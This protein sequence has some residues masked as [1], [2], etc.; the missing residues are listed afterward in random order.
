M[1]AAGL[2][3]PDV[4]KVLLRHEADKTLVDNDNESASDH[5]RNSGHSEIVELLK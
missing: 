4:V 5:A 1:M 2:G 3:Q